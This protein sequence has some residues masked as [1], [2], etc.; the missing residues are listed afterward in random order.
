VMLENAGAHGGTVAAPIAQYVLER[1][2]KREGWV[3]P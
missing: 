2:A 1:Y 3:A